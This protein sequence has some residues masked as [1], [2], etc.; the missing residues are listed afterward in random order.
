ML[1]VLSVAVAMWA[2]PACALG[3]EVRV[4]ARCYREGAP[5]AMTA[6]GFSPGSVFAAII[7]GVRVGGGL[8]EQAGAV[9]ATFPAPPLRGRQDVHAVGVI[10]AA[11]S[12]AAAVF[13]V[14]RPSAR[15]YP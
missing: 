14:S 6:A 2:W 11:G 3:A 10:D 4:D 9:Q 12:A 8:V 7:D 1:R 13:F 5:V 15:L